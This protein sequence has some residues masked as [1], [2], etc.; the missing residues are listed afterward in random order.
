MSIIYGFAKKSDRSLDIFM[1]ERLTPEPSK[2]SIFLG[3][4]SCDQYEKISPTYPHQMISLWEKI[5]FFLK[6]TSA[7]AYFVC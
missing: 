7:D 6:N 4:I 3:R 2:N 5:D 1:V